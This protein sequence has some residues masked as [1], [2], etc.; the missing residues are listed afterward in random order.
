MKGDDVIGIIQGKT[1][2]AFRVDIG[3]GEV[4]VL[5][6]LSFEGA[7]RRSYPDL[8]ASRVENLIKI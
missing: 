6:I 2:D 1:P 8:K 3:S 4:A 5:S 7:T